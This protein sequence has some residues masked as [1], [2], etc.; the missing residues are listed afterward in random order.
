MIT[1]GHTD[2]WWWLY[3]RCRGAGNGG[4]GDGDDGAGVGGLAFIVFII[5][6]FSASLFE[7]CL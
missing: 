1:I 6:F 2:A 7:S 4:R 5:A 3:A